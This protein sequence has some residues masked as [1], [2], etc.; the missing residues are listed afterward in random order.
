MFLDGIW[1]KRAWGGEVENVAVL[2]A[3]AVGSDGYREVLGVAR[4]PRKIRRVGGTSCGT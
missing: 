3:I 2:V 1:L 4:A